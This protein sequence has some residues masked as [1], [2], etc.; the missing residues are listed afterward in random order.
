VEF[1]DHISPDDPQ[2]D[3]DEP[4]QSLPR[5]TSEDNPNVP[6]IYKPFFGFDPYA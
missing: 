6:L 5:I 2:L 1:R 4:V 3:F